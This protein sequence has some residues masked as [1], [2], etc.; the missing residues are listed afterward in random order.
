[1]TTSK[2]IIGYTALGA[3]TGHG[4][5]YWR[6]RSSVENLPFGKYR[7]PYSYQPCFEAAEVDAYLK[8]GR[9]DWEGPALSM[10]LADLITRLEEA[11]GLLHEVVDDRG[12]LGRLLRVGQKGD[13]EYIEKLTESLARD[14]GW[15][16]ILAGIAANLARQASSRRGSS[17][18]RALY[19]H[20]P[21]AAIEAIASDFVYY[22]ECAEAVLMNMDLFNSK[23]ESTGEI[24]DKQNAG[25]RAPLTK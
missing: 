8:L 25:K 18:V 1:M 5:D 22:R 7:I 20:G 19:A 9:P 2:K 6:N 15:L 12:A 21:D 11:A 3:Y 10:E 24:L 16:S 17:Y 13:A 14:A 4:G 23:N